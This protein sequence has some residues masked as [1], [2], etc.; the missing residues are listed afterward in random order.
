MT[1]TSPRLV[2]GTSPEKGS[3]IVS[4]VRP[5]RM[6]LPYSFCAVEVFRDGSGVDVRDP[7]SGRQLCQLDC[8][9]E[10]FEETWAEL[11]PTFSRAYLAG[12]ADGKDAAGQAAG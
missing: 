9:Y 11:L 2:L 12:D 5:V 10:R 1:P 8:K 4:L 6:P 3:K 7:D